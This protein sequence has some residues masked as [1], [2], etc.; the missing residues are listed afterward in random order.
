MKIQVLKKRFTKDVLEKIIEIDKTF[1]HDFDFS[2]TD[3][4]FKRY[5]SKNIVYVLIINDE[6]VGYFNLLNIS[7]KLFDD[8]CALKYSQDYSFPE[9]DVNVNTNY[10][11]MP[12]LVVKEEYRKYSICLIL[13]LKEVVKKSKNFVVIAVSNEGKILASKCLNKIGNKKK[14]TIFAKIDK[15]SSDN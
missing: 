4:Y 8:I 10:V 7:K 3:W 11:Y 2:E 12:S 9:S 6:V 15:K 1:Y 13:K 14:A 5:N